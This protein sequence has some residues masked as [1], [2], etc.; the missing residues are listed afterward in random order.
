MISVAEEFV[1]C[2]LVV[3][4]IN[5]FFQIFIDAKVEGHTALRSCISFL[6]AH[7]SNSVL[8]ATLFLSYS[9]ALL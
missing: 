7:I 6:F 3:D 8:I 9:V 2:L 1:C 4:L 5:L